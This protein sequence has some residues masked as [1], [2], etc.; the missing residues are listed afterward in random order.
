[1]KNKIKIIITIENGQRL[2][3]QQKE[4]EEKHQHMTKLLQKL[5]DYICQR[6]KRTDEVDIVMQIIT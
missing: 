4:L 1:M 2:L 5:E 3:C 6:E